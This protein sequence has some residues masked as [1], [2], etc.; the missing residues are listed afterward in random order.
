MGDLGR[1]L[2]AQALKI[3]PKC[4][5]SSNLVTLVQII[6]ILKHI[7]VWKLPFYYPVQ[8]F[9]PLI[10]EPLLHQGHSQ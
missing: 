2:L 9:E 3:C 1:I 7:T 8:G 6:N 4:N 5:K 10:S